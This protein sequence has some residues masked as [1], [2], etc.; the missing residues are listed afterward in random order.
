MAVVYA[1]LSLVMLAYLAVRVYL[2]ARLY[3]W[4]LLHLI[5]WAR[6]LR[7]TD[8]WYVVGV[9]LLGFWMTGE[10]LRGTFPGTEELFWSS[11]SLLVVLVGH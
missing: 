4:N 6:P 11:L 3:R 1:F 2:T 8:K 9:I 7:S 10:F 5:E